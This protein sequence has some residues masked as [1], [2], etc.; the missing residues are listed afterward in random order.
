MPQ[1]RTK[2]VSEMLSPETAVRLYSYN[3]R[4][5]SRYVSSV[6][7]LDWNEATR[8]RETGHLSL[9]ST[10]V[11]ILNVHEVWISYIMQGRNSDAEL[12]A[13]FSDP[14]RKPGSWKEFDSYNRRVWK[15]IDSYLSSL[16]G[17]AMS[18]E[19][20]AFWMPG[21]Y[22]VSD[23]LMQATFEQAHHLGEI[24]GAMWQ[25]DLQP[26]KMTWIEIGRSTGRK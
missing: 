16:T 10:L 13:L 25:Q 23:G 24:I 3:R 9:F 2:S 26:P 6:K 8:N 18:K 17:R 22:T 5:F 12:E 19:V 4:L 20:H 7:K 1:S 15:G 21:R 11:H 14:A